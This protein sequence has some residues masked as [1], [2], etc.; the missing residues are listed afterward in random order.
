MDVISNR[1]AA[2]GIARR[3]LQK[4]IVPFARMSTMTT[5]TSTAA[6][7]TS[8]VAI[9]TSSFVSNNV[10]PIV[11]GIDGSDGNGY[12]D[13][14]NAIGNALKVFD[15]ERAAVAFQADTWQSNEMGFE[16]N[17]FTTSAFMWR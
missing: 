9:T 16:V 5:A 7:V 15:N 12:D 4:R 17:I 10:W 2:L 1:L 13:S 14:T 3:V 8:T 6:S 11:G